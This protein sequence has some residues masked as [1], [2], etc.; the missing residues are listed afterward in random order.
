MDIAV[1]HHALRW[2]EENLYTGV[3]V[4]DLVSTTGYSRRTFETG[5]RNHY[6]I[7]P[8][9]YLFRRRMTRAT[10]MLK[11]TQLPVTEIAT[12][13]HYYSG[14]NFSRAF[15][16]FYGQSPSDCRGTPE[17]NN[18][19]LQAPLL[20]SDMAL[21]GV[22]E[23]L[24]QPIGIMGCRTSYEACYTVIN[25]SGLPE[26]LRSAVSEKH[27]TDDVFV[28][29]SIATPADLLTAR[30][31]DINVNVF[32]GIKVDNIAAAN[33]V[34]EA[35]R[36]VRFDFRGTPEE[37]AVFSKKI[38]A[39]TLAR[40]NCRWAGNLSFIRVYAFDNEISCT[41]YIPVI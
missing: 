27:T 16:R 14:Q 32:I 9:E 22:I 33:E 2:V 7:S 23:E 8:G 40:H 26:K 28:V 18:D 6:G 31:G 1:F 19:V 11:L 30:R 10:V 34:I 37:Y 36:Y 25:H 3:M 4:G 35:G 15:R 5:F 24:T 39:Q 38:Y 12:Q 41:L 17:W 13:F 20:Q 21:K 29:F